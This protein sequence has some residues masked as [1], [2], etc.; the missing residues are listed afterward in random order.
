M[1]LAGLGQGAQL[2]T[3]YLSQV[4]RDR[5]TPSLATLTALGRILKVDLRYFFEDEADTAYVV[6]SEHVL[7]DGTDGL[8]DTSLA[9]TPGAGDQNLTVNRIAIGPKSSSG[10]LPTFE[11]D[12]LIFVLTGFLVVEIGDER[13][14]LG[15]GDSVHYDAKKPHSWG[16]ERDECCVILRSKVLASLE[17]RPK[18][19]RR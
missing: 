9:L 4:E 8:V 3:S 19:G 1:T 14:S 5:T 12:E 13:Y 18:P 10:P 11:G 17:R 2:S 6:R 15:P 7:S 16:N